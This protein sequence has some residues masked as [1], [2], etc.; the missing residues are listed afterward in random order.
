LHTIPYLIGSV[1][2]QR[3]RRKP[4]VVELIGG[5]GLP[6]AVLT[7]PPNMKISQEKAEEI[8]KR[9]E[10]QLSKPRSDEE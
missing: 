4:T 3:L 7:F 8:K 5:D 10:E 2:R 6:C 1:F 9:C